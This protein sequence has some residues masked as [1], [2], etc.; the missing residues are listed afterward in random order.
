MIHN[1]GQFD[2][3]GHPAISVPCGMEDDLPIGL[4]LVG[5]HLDE[6]TD[7]AGQLDIF[8]TARRKLRLSA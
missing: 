6:A 2:V 4:Q 3:T 8:S 1:T 7:P 5:R